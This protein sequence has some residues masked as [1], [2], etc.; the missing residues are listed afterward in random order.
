MFEW[1]FCSTAVILKVWQYF[2]HFLMSCNSA[3]K[4]ACGQELGRG[5]LTSECKDC[6]FLFHA[7][8]KM[9]AW[10][11]YFQVSATCRNPSVSFR[12]FLMLTGIK[13]EFIFWVEIS[14]VVSL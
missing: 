12:H 13:N 8:E 4:L 9:K 6:F 3:L 10:L 1:C 11:N 2:P 14:M 7:F 5:I